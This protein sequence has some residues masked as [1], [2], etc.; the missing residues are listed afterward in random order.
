[1]DENQKRPVDERG[2]YKDGAQK[3]QE[4]KDDMIFPE[5]KNKKE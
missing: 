3:L 1:M 2:Y 5:R 4:D